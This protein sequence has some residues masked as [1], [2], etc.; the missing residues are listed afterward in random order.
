MRT[1][2]AGCKDYGL[3]VDEVILLTSMCKRKNDCFVS[4]LKTA[5]HESNENIEQE[6]FRNLHEQ[7]SY[8]S[9]EAEM[10]LKGIPFVSRQDFYGYRR[11][12]L[13]LFKEKLKENDRSTVEQWKKNDYIRRYL[14]KKEAEKETGMKECKLMDLAKKAEAVLKIGNMCLINMIALYDYLDCEYGKV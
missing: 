4:A 11:R 6:L 12:T 14:S 10:D 7:I 5:A 1:R 13:F 3:K 8:E 9:L 2:E